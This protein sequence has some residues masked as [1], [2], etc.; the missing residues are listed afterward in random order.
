MIGFLKKYYPLLAIALVAVRL[1]GALARRHDE[2]GAVQRQMAQLLGLA[3][4]AHIELDLDG[5]VLRTSVR[6]GVPLNRQHRTFRGPSLHRKNRS[7]TRRSLLGSSTQLEVA[8]TAPT[9]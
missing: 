1:W 6:A 3:A 4:H 5:R 9:P 8:Q 2:S 7:R